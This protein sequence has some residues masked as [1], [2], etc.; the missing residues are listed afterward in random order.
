MGGLKDQL[1]KAGLVNEKQVKKAQKE[2]RKETLQHGRK[3]SE[4]AQRV[5]Q[6]VAEKAERDRQLNLQRKE[7]ADRKAVAAQIKQLIE[8][9]RIA[10][11]EGETPYN[12][13]DGQTV[14][15]LHVSDKIRNQI[16]RGQLAIV[17]LDK[18]YELI[19]AAIADKIRLRDPA[20]IIV[21][22]APETTTSTDN[23]PYA[24]YQIPDDLM[25]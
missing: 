12:F 15:R 21:Q 9:H 17:K 10:P 25:W 8:T 5:Q 4:E 11:G 20:C 23:D 2:Q 19:P 7:E 13:A 22:N 24:A 3:P 18:S 6:A 14:K 1:L 16:I